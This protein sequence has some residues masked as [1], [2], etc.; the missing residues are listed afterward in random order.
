MIRKII[1]AGTLL[2]A[3]W[4]A[5]AQNKVYMEQVGSGSTITILQDG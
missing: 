1:T 4:A 2:A 5:Q 3:A